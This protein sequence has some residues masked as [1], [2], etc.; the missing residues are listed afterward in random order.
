MKIIFPVEADTGDMGGSLSHE[1]QYVTDVGENNLLKCTKCEF[2]TN[3]E[4]A[5][6]IE[7][8]PKCKTTLEKHKGL[9]VNYSL[10]KNFIFLME[11]I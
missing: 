3:V 1:Y 9:E 6:D 7:S 8:C 10:I 4:L 2:A 5:G 11:L